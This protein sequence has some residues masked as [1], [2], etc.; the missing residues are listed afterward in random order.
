MAAPRAPRRRRRHAR[1]RRV[2]ARDRPAAGAPARLGAQ[3][4]AAR[5]SSASARRGARSARRTETPKV[6]L[7]GYTNVGKSTL[8]NALTGAE[9]SVENRLFET[10]DPT[11][12]GFEHD[13]RR[14]LVTDTVG[15]IRRLPHQLVEG[16]AATL[17][18]TLVADMVLHV[19]DALAPDEDGR[20][21]G[22]RPSRTCSHE[23]GAAELPLELVLNKI[24]RVDE[25]GRRRLAQPLPRRAAG[26][27]LDAA[28]G[29]T[30][31]SARIAERFDE[32]W[33]RVRLLVPYDEGARLSE[34]YALG[35]PIE[36][37][38]DTPDGVLVVARLP[39]RELHALRAVPD[40][41]VA[42]HAG[43]RLIELPF[44]RLRAGRGDPD[45]CV[46]RRRRPRPRPPASASSSGPG[47]R[48]LV[49][50]RARGRD[51]GGLCGLCPAAL[52]PRGE[53]RDLDRQHA[54][55][56]RL[57]LPRRAEGQPP[58]HRP[59]ESFVVEPGMRI[60]QLVVLR[61]RRSSWSRSTSCR[62]AS[63]ASAASARPGTDGEPR[64]R[65]AALLGW[66]DRVLLCR[67]EKPGKEYWLLPGGGVDGGETLIEAL[68][69][70]L[71]EELGI[72]SDVQFEGP[73]A[74]VDSI[75]PE[76]AARAKARRPHH[77]RRPTSRTARSTTSRRGTPPS[78]ARA[79]SRSRS[80][81]GRP[82]PADQ[83]LRG[84]A[85]GRATRRCTSASLWAR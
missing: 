25:V 51:P 62:T 26:L 42:Q 84:S 78:A 31:C 9:V 35:A 16:F 38:E 17:E 59:R 56:R 5:T 21:A 70:E 60:A 49:A 41:R 4:A 73:I 18:E 81:R 76:L 67:Q 40:R 10:L 47:E 64:I 48:A 63:A 80:S 57:G 7:A 39:R 54:G 55:P 1:P 37:R 28:R 34:L 20:P 75:A 11:T 13:G 36:E 85:G 19:V 3:A 50:D 79:C 29:S 71:R 53:A 74:I 22:R 66:Q 30:S 43:V 46:R 2:A 52:R 6:A 14:Y 33:E 24:D 15:F 82:P 58:Q 65:V 8:L 69:R 83:A 44:Q 27:G 68:R 61:Y 45:A 77:L 12:R 23:I 72:E 32:R